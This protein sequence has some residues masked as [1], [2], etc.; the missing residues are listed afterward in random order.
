MSKAANNATELD[1]INYI[2]SNNSLNFTATVIGNANVY[3]TGVQGI[4]GVGAFFVWS[5]IVPAQ[6]SNWVDI[7]D[8]QVESWVDVDTTQTNNWQDVLAA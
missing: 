3:L 6:A 8:A 2:P 7:N 5:D 4:G 1:L